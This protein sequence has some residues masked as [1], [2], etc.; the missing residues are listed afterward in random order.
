MKTTSI[1]FLLIISLFLTICTPARSQNIWTQTNGP[2]GG[3]GAAIAI[4]STGN[5]FAG[6][7]A[8]GIFRSSDRGGRWEPVRN[9]LRP[10]RITSIAVNSANVIF[11]ATTELW[12]DTDYVYI[13]TDH[14]NNWARSKRGIYYEPIRELRIAPNDHIFARQDFADYRSTDNGATWTEITPRNTVR[15]WRMAIGN[16]GYIYVANDSGL[17]R[18]TNDGSSWKLVQRSSHPVNY[19]VFTAQNGDIYTQ[20]IAPSGAFR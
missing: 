6:L 9:G 5:I 10:S 1:N 8:G 17:Y 13:S 16:N 19:S 2:N 15:Q 3:G 14:G 7:F 4:D 11:A 18:S 12:N 20:D